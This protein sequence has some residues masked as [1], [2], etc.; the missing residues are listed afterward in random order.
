MKF[1][2]LRHNIRVSVDYIISYQQY[3]SDGPLYLVGSSLEVNSII[4]TNKEY[5]YVNE[6]VEELDQLFLEAQ[7]S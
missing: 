1:I 7:K 2:K 4:I 3:V 5:V 6:T